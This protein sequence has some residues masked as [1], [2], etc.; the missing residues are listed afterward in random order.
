MRLIGVEVGDELGKVNARGIGVAGDAQVGGLRHRLDD[1]AI[2]LAHAGI[3]A[4][5]DAKI[6]VLLSSW[7]GSDDGVNGDGNIRETILV[8]VDA[9]V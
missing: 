7:V 9:I 1:E 5:P 3:I 8:D 6:A 2:T 4:Q